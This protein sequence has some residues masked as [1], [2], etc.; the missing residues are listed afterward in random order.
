MG[1]RV[2]TGTPPCHDADWDRACRVIADVAPLLPSGFAYEAL[3]AAVHAHADGRGLRKKTIKN[4]LAAHGTRATW[5]GR[6]GGA[7]VKRASASVGN[8][9]THTDDADALVRRAVA[10]ALDAHPGMLPM[11][12]AH[13]KE[14]HRRAPLS[15]I[16]RAVLRHALRRLPSPDPPAPTPSVPE[17]P[18]AE[19]SNPSAAAAPQ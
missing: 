9:G 6:D 12:R 18:E 3:Y 17:V 4:A 5:S 11:S 15:G 13:R 8:P 2:H 14:V 16:T 19:P 7:I 10:E 1:K